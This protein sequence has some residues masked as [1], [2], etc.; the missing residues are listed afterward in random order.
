MLTAC[1]HVDRDRRIHSTGQRC[2]GG[3]NYCGHLEGTLRQSLMTA[4]MFFGQWYLLPADVA[5]SLGRHSEAVY[6]YLV[7]G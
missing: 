7:W 2:S 4:V 5:C 3:R 6:V 1:H